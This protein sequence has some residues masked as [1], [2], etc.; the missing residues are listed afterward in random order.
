M[1]KVLGIHLPS[2]GQHAKTSYRVVWTGLLC[3]IAIALL[4]A[5]EFELQRNP[6]PTAPLTP[7]PAAAPTLGATAAS[8]P[9]PAT[10]PDPTATPDTVVRMY[11]TSPPPRQPLFPV[12]LPLHLRSF[13]LCPTPVRDPFAHWND[14][15][16]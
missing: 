8:T 4:S 16:P 2:V 12:L 6:E 10:S 11:E 5:C 1:R 13:H 3:S 7:G 9:V 15:E 14:L